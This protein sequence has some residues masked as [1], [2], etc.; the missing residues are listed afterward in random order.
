MKLPTLSLKG[1]ARPKESKLFLAMVPTFKEKRVQQ[2]T[3]LSLTLVTIAFFGLFAINPTLGT[4]ADLQKQLEDSQFIHDALQTKIAN[5]TT[6]QTQYTQ[7]EP[8][9][10]PV[11]SAV[12][13]TPGID[14]LVGQVHQIAQQSSLQLNRVQTLPIDL[15]PATLS[16]AKYLAY[17]FSIEAQGDLPTLQKFMSQLATFNRLISF[18]TVNFSKVGRI[19]NT[20]RATIRGRTY[21]KQGESL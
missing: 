16:K 8:D 19:D 7:L 4:I 20:F 9:L 5:L 12:P 3:T 14:S 18:D 13:Q 10:N 21:F 2:F 11:F 17:A 1:F 15:S 6:L